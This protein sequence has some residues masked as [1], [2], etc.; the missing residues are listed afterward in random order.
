LGNERGET[1]PTNIKKL[2]EAKGLQQKEMALMLG[3]KS[4]AKYNEIENGNR[5]L[6]VKKALLAAEILG[7]SL[8]EIF[9]PSNFP[10]RT[11]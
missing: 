8:D 10:K 2:R 1:M 9:L 4:I 7:C 11:K 5:P 6:P 3:Y